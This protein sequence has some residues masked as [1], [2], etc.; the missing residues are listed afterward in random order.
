MGMS[1][2]ARDMLLRAYGVDCLAS[3]GKF[4]VLGMSLLM[5]LFHS[6]NYCLGHS[7]TNYTG[8]KNIPYKPTS[9]LQNR[10]ECKEFR[11]VV[12]VLSPTKAKVS[13]K[14]VHFSIC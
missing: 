7:E 6:V 3:H 5:G 9:W 8:D 13:L 11:F 12:D 4:L 10:M 14:S 1:L 2:V